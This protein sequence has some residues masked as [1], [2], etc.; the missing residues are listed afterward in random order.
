MGKMIPPEEE[1]D[2]VKVEGLH[3]TMGRIT[4]MP[5]PEDTVTTQQVITS[6]PIETIGQG[7]VAPVDSAEPQIDVVPVDEPRPNVR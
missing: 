6:E 1:E 7:V 5:E 2:T 3:L 4:I